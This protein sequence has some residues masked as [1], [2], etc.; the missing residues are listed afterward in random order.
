MHISEPL[1]LVYITVFTALVFNF[2]NGFHDAANAIA[3]VVSTQVLK[4]HQAVIWSS[5]FNFMA[6]FVFGLHVA[7]T[8]GTG[9]VSPEI[10]NTAFIFSAL[11]GAIVWNIITWYF[12]IPSSSSHAL[13]GGLVGAALVKSGTTY[14]EYAGL[15]KTIIAIF[16]SPI[17]GMIIALLLMFLTA[18]VF[19]YTAPFQTDRWF[20]RLQ[21][22][23]SA[24]LSLGHGG[25]DAQKSM[26]IIAVMLFSSHLLTG[27]FYVPTWVIV[28]CYLTM[29]LGTLFGGYR[30]VRTMG[31][32]ITKLKPVGGCCAE[33]GSALTLFIATIF[34]IPVS[35]TH[36]V[37]GSI[38]GVGSLHRFSAVRWGVASQ[39]VWAWVLTVPASAIVAGLIEYVA[40][41]YFN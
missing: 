26:G 20:R 6:Y 25:N 19:F 31:M 28:S 10:I 17:L 2:L 18:R 39:M 13:I 30:I 12:G 22:A 33:T 14:L 41:H 1:L 15:L 11:M 32:K 38:I 29:A 5:F 23:S 37:A 9:I 7:N 27:T 16:V 4:P 24:L 3:T 34:G 40:L 8:V 35:T 21:L 36:I